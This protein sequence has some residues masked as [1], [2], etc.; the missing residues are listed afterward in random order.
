MNLINIITDD[1]TQTMSLKL[2]NGQN[3]SFSLWYSYNQ[4]GWFYSFTYGTYKSTNRRMVQSL[5]MIRAI[6][7]VIPFGL[8]CLLTDKNEPVFIEDFK[9][10]RAALY[11]LN[12]SDVTKVESL[13]G[14]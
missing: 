7:N 3:L 9:S 14:T 11:T 12:Q 13:L 1:P 6:K 4:K 2:D 10:G 8:A 5:N